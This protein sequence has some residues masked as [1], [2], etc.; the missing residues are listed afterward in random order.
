MKSDL[1]DE[2]P[3]PQ[4][5]ASA[6]R[7]EDR[8]RWVSIFIRAG[9]AIADGAR[10]DWRA[11]ERLARRP[12]EVALLRKLQKIEDL[13]GHCRAH[14]TAL[15][16]TGVDESLPLQ[17]LAAIQ[18]PS[19]SQ[20]FLPDELISNRFRVKSLLGRGGMAD[21]YEAWD[22]D[23]GIPVALKMLHV[24]AGRERATIRSLKHEAMLA[25]AVVHPNVCRVYDLGCHGDG[26]KSVWFLTMEVLRGVTQGN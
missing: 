22:E 3:R 12:Q 18:H 5:P 21:V 19:P 11:M 26:E 25:R 1:N 9:M 20:P 23:L 16:L 15:P 4:V 6:G 2:Q 17:L 24:E 14:E 7:G 10:T 8:K 13:A